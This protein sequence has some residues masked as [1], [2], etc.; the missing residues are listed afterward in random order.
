MARKRIEIVATE[1]EREQSLPMSRS[2]SLSELGD[3]FAFVGRQRP[4]RIDD[5]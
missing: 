1:L 5:T 4:L 3:D 2:R